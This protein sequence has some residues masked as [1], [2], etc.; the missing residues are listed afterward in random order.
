[1]KV[2]QNMAA[3][4]HFLIV[5]AQE[6]IDF[7]I[8]EI[9]SLVSHLGIQA[10][11]TSHKYEEKS[12]FLEIDLPSED[13]MQKLMNRS[14][15][16]R[17]AIEVWAHGSTYSEVCA[18]LDAVP[19][20]EMEKYCKEDVSF[21]FKVHTFGKQLSSA[22]KLDTMKRLQDHLPLKGPVK[23]RDPDQ[24][25]Y[26]F[27]DYGVQPNQAPDK[28]HRIFVG[29]W[30]SDGQKRLAHRYSVKTRHFIGN[31]SM[32]ALLSLVMTNQAGV[33]EGDLVL[34]PFVGTGSLLVAA[35]HFGGYVAGCDINYNI[36]HG[37]GKSSRAQPKT[38]TKTKYR[39]RDENISAN[40]EQYGLGHR[41]LDV[42]ISDFSQD[43]WREQ[44]LFDA[45]ITD[46]PYGI[47]EKTRKVGTEKEHGARDDQGSYHVPVTQSYFLSDIFTDLLNFSAHHLRLHGRLVYF[48]PIYRPE[49]SEDQI[50]H[51]PCLKIV[52]NDEQILNSSM[53]RRLITMEKTH[54]VSDASTSMATISDNKYGEHNAIRDKFLVQNI[55]KRLKSDDS[56]SPERAA[57]TVSPERAANTETKEEVACGSSLR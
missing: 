56:V 26:I 15:L 25:F 12:P 1:M 41:Y 49:Y 17:S 38:E 57:D 5:F 18:G 20:D 40:L 14:V 32:D 46:P 11:L 45:I 16:S 48:L 3:M 7:R 30:I 50:P 27:E 39:G 35:A 54:H 6:H 22:A 21:C 29:R 28:P 31:T 9:K 55:H 36:I 2:L 33:Q 24:V 34:D 13:C 44:P 47:R 19:R 37:R 43:I 4:R 10:D 52:A 51:H 42:L 8:S 23:M 53:S